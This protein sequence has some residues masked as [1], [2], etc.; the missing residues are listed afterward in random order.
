MLDSNSLEV[1]HID[2]SPHRINA[3]VKDESSPVAEPELSATTT[4]P[5]PLEED[6]LAASGRTRFP[7]PDAAQEYLPDLLAK[8]PGVKVSTRGLIKPLHIVQPEG[9]SFTMN[10]N[11]LQWQKWKMH[12]GELLWYHVIGLPE[13]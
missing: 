7:Y 11:E 5:P 10:G 12:V 1:I 9:V 6:S 3:R 2:F 8:Q 4:A 13:S